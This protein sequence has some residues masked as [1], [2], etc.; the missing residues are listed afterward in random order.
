[1]IIIIIIIIIIYINI[2]IYTY[3]YTYI[4]IYIYMVFITEGF[5]RSSYGK[6]AWVGFEPTTTEYIYILTFY[7][8]TVKCQSMSTK[9]LELGHIRHTF[10]LIESQDQYIY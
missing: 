3:I 5:F 9:D 2:Y 7:T 4:Y 1:M 10:S 8:F 6:L